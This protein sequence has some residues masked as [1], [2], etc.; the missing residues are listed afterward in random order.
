MQGPGSSVAGSAPVAAGAG[1]HV[2]AGASR[3]CHRCQ[4]D[5]N[6][7]AEPF[8]RVGAYSFHKECFV[9]A[10][11]HTQLH[12]K[13]FQCN[14]ADQKFYCS[15][16]YNQKFV[17]ECRGCHK[18]IS[19]GKIITSQSLDA[20]YHP[21]CFVCV[22]CSRPFAQGR[23]VSAAT[24]CGGIHTFPHACPQVLPAR[25]QAVLRRPH[26]RGQGRALRSVPPA[27]QG[28][29]EAARPGVHL[30][31]CVSGLQSVQLR[32][33]RRPGCAAAAQ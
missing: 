30:P 5:I 11:C 14:P 13:Q 27:R 2:A 32:P 20:S 28:Q 29:R 21:D 9:C 16:D 7:V 18:K 19:T 6:H 4:K 3:T 25:G 8:I 1:Q 22:V 23:C 31:R 24:V 33:R 10:E 12:G 26:P 17:R 15:E